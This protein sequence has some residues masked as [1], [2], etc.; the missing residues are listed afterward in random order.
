[1]K[2]IFQLMALAFAVMTL[3]AC[4]DFLE[5]YSQDEFE[6][7]TTTAF[8]ELLMGAGY[9]FAFHMGE[10][11]DILSDDAANVNPNPSTPQYYYTAQTDMLLEAFS[12]Q[13]TIYQSLEEKTSNAVSG[14]E[15]LYQDLYGKIMPCNI[16]IESTPESQGSDA[17][18]ANVMGQAYALRAMY[19]FQL[20][21]LYAKPY[22]TEGT[23]PDRLAGV[24]LITASE[25][26]DEG[27]ARSSVAAV[28]TQ[29]AYDIEQAITLLGQEK[30]NN[31]LLRIGYTAACAFASRVFLY[32][33]QWDKV[34]EYATE[35]LRYAPKLANYNTFDWGYT[36][37]YNKPSSGANHILTRNYPENIWLGGFMSSYWQLTGGYTFTVSPNLTSMFADNDVRKTEYFSSNW[38]GGYVWH[39]AGNNSEFSS[40]IR[41]AELYLNRAEAY[42]E[43]YA[44]GQADA[45]AKAVADLN[46]LCRNRYTNYTAYALSTADALREELRAERRRELCFEGHRW[47]DLRR[48]GMPQIE[49]IFIDAANVANKYTLQAG[50]PAYVLPF[51]P[52]AL[53]R[54]PNLEQNELAPRREPTGV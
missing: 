37:A 16:V 24:P 9:N 52:A 41:T 38:T 18:K 30:R 14:N 6:P 35:A 25:I 43:Q 34:V 7:E 50:D 47:F 13:S 46:E 32:M 12:W 21:N 10:M 49:H 28:Y 22:N 1:M 29:I 20:V 54:N 31:G 2:K 53:M 26:L 40:V 39:K 4:S 19:Y 5:E 51:P 45:G 17:D 15:K 3:G 36:N 48:Y 42:M 27:P 23:T 11:L 8:D 44:A 33:E